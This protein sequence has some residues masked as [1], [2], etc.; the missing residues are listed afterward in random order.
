M[1]RAACAAAASCEAAG[2]AATLTRYGRYERS[3]ELIASNMA[4]CSIA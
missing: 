3:M 4:M 2:Q 1:S